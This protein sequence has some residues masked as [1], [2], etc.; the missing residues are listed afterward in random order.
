MQKIAVITGGTEGIGRA[1]VKKLIH[2]GYQ[3]FTC[4]R[5]ERALI[6]LKQTLETPNC[7]ITFQVADLSHKKDVLKFA[8]LVKQHKRLDV[9]V[10][11]AGV[12]L[13]GAIKDEP[14]TNLEQLIATNLYSAYYL[15]KA[16]LPLMCEQESGTI[17]NICSIASLTAYAGGA[18]YAI[19]KHALL[20]FSRSLRAELKSDAIRVSTILPGATY[21]RSWSA[22]GLPPERFMPAEDVAELVAT[23][24][25]LSPR[26]VVEDIVLRPLLG[27]I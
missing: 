23:I 12:F 9:L 18:S 4:A 20:G 26:T 6:E 2:D 24:C 13:G 25:K 27:D 1:I 14:D 22:S 8:D 16:L 3:I 21:T 15:T 10:N 11:N 19:S 5:H 17:I 7:K